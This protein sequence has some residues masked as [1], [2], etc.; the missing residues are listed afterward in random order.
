VFVP[1]CSEVESVTIRKTEILDQLE[2]AAF[3]V[4]S[5]KWKMPRGRIDVPVK[6]AKRNKCVLWN[7]RGTT[8]GGDRGDPGHSP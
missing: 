4:F 5:E 1:H 7:D 3:A 2:Q 8:A 6:V